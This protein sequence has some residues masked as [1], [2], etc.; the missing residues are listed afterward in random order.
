MPSLR[1]TPKEIQI[2]DLIKL[3]YDDKKIATELGIATGTVKA[4]LQLIFAKLQAVNR[5]DAVVKAIRAGY[6][7]LE[8]K[9]G[10]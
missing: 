3:G 4:H 2:L 7:S 8:V 10:R 5:V 9:G 1:L 6:L